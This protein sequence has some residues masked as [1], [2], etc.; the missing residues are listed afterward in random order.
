MDETYF[1]YDHR[2]ADGYYDSGNQL[3]GRVWPERSCALAR[4]DR[5]APAWKR[6]IDAW[7]AK[8]C[9][10]LCSDDPIP[11]MQFAL[12]DRGPDPAL[13]ASRLAVVSRFPWP[14]RFIRPGN[15]NNALRFKHVDVAELL[16]LMIEERKEDRRSFFPTDRFALSYLNWGSGRRWR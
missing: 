1:D 10:R 13:A 14:S 3:E 4:C 7:P 12:A 8:A 5:C 2:A 6:A 16:D 15:N 11:M 9:S